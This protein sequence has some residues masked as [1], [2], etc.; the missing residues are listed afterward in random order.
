M[1]NVHEKICEMIS[2]TPE[3]FDNARIS[4]SI[5]EPTCKNLFNYDKFARLLVK[6]RKNLVFRSVEL[7]RQGN[8][9]FASLAKHCYGYRYLVERSQ[10]LIL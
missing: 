5:D 8:Q 9:K 2:A 6:A 10:E 1:H 3:R 4:I 7:I